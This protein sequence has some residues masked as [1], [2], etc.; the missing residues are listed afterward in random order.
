MKKFAE[1]IKHNLVL[2]VFSLILAILLWAF[3]Q[4]M[5]NP[6]IGYDSVEIPLTI[7]GV[8]NLNNTN[9]TL[10]DSP[11][12]MPISVTISAKP[13]YIS[14][15]KDYSIVANLDV[16]A[17]NDL[18]EYT[19]PINVY[20]NDPNIRIISHTPSNIMVEADHLT[21]IVKPV[22]ISYA[23]LPD[24]AYYIDQDKAVISPATT[25]VIMPQSK[26]ANEYRVEIDISMDNVSSDINGTYSAVLVDANGN[27]VTDRSFSIV[28]K[29][30]HVQVPILRKKTVP[31]EITDPPEYLVGKYEVSP[32]TVQIAVPQ[33]EWESITKV[34]GTI[35]Y[36]PNH[37]RD[38][39]RVVLQPPAGVVVVEDT[40]VL[41]NIV[42]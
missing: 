22:K 1:I 41:L 14:P 2:K 36:D 10:I 35:A 15:G 16:S 19:L 29:S 3:V 20:S 39:Y 42:E 28:D 30:F 40:D 26:V 25:E 31:V 7:E 8:A 18:G 21:S 23:N 11:E 27:R 34:Y 13:T 6:E 9:L 12:H 38:Y 33:E 4:L 24:A 32:A 37:E 5:E 17:I